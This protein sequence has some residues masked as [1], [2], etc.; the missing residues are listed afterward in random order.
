MT[1]HIIPL[2]ELDKHDDS[3]TCHCNPYLEKFGDDLFIAHWPVLDK[4]EQEEEIQKYV[5]GE[6]TILSN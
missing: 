2:G 3:A 6:F 1:Y 5:D 4:E